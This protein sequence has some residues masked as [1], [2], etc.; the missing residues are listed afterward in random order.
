MQ[1]G[2]GQ[3]RGGEL[4]GQRRFDG[5]IGVPVAPLLKMCGFRVSPVRNFVTLTVSTNVSCDSESIVIAY[6]KVVRAC[7][8]AYE[9]LLPVGS[10]DWLS[11]FV[12]GTSAAALG[13][14]SPN[15]TT[16]RRSN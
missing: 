8:T 3:L 15:Y 14:T 2:Q 11:S 13:G 4:K 16:R 7:Q 1:S 6:F 9:C 10:R 12:S 5:M